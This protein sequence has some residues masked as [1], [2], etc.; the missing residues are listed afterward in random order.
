[1]ISRE[2]PRTKSILNRD[3]AQRIAG[4]MDAFRKIPFE[5]F[6]SGQTPKPDFGCNLPSTRSGNKNDIA[7][8]FNN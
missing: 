7:V 4:G 5:V 3:V 1:M 6:G 2:P 8:V